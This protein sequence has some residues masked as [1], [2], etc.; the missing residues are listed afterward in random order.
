MPRWQASTGK[1]EAASYL[2][3]FLN[4]NFEFY[5]VLLNCQS[6]PAHPIDARHRLPYRTSSTVRTGNLIGTSTGDRYL[7]VPVARTTTSGLAY[8]TKQARSLYQYGT[9]PVPVRNDDVNLDSRKTTTSLPDELLDS[10]LDS[11]T[12]MSRLQ[13]GRVGQD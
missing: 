8:C 13:C 12:S 6:E 4:F 3:W 1:D 11:H 2:L 5:Y 10:K 9:V 7:T